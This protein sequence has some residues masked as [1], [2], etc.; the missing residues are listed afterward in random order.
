[1]RRL[2]SVAGGHGG[3]GATLELKIKLSIN[4][5]GRNTYGTHVG[6]ANAQKL[7]TWDECIRA[8]C[9]RD[10]CRWN[11]CRE[12]ACKMNSDGLNADG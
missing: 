4:A 5:D 9:T 3:N 2:I 11:E 7:C 12:N 6:R 8:D 10:A 1:M